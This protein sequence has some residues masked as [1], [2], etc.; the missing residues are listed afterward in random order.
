MHIPFVCACDIERSGRHRGI[1]YDPHTLDSNGGEEP[2]MKPLLCELFFGCKSRWTALRRLASLFG[3]TL[4][5]PRITAKTRFSS[6]GMRLFSG[7]AVRKCEKSMRSAIV[8]I[9][10]YAPSRRWRIF[11]RLVDGGL[12]PRR[13]FGIRPVVAPGANDE[14]VFTLRGIQHEFV[15]TCPAHDS[16]IGFDGNRI[17]AASAENRRY[18]L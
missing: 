2:G 1:E 6:A 12:E 16:G 17:Q 11:R 13:L 9:R 7:S 18:A 15:R 8:L 3:E 10:E 14:P 4:K 5:S